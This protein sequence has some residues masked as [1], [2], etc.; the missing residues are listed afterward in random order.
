MHNAMLFKY[1]SI[2]TS[3]LATAR[4]FSAV[5]YPIL[6]V[7]YYFLIRSRFV[8]FMMYNLYCI[9]IFGLGRTFFRYKRFKRGEAPVWE[10]IP[11]FCFHHDNDNVENMTTEGHE[12]EGEAN[13]GEPGAA[14]A[15]E[16]DF[17]ETEP[18]QL[19]DKE[20]VAI[21]LECEKEVIDVDVTLSEREVES[22]LGGE[23]NEEDMDIQGAREGGCSV[24]GEKAPT[25]GEKCQEWWEKKKKEIAVHLSPSWLIP[26]TFIVV[27][28]YIQYVVLGNL[29]VIYQPMYSLTGMSVSSFLV[30]SSF[31]GPLGGMF[32]P[33]AG[34]IKQFLGNGTSFFTLSLVGV[35]VC[36]L[37]LILI[38]EVQFLTVLMNGVFRVAMNAVGYAYIAD[39]QPEEY[40]GTLTTDLMLVT[41][42]TALATYPTNYVSYQLL[43]G[44]MIPVTIFLLTLGILRFGAAIY[45]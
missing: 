37:L 34:T 44:D 35:S 28:V 39:E 7:I 33:L 21:A 16:G 30:V 23:E 9:V 27:A 13:G 24:S 32:G 29:P 8:V 6:F 36:I 22:A 18:Q 41:I 10:P 4:E 12:A 1:V 3:G 2:S 43:E 15:T 26:L 14:A 45:F 25:A 19:E 42:Y 40:Y 31:V 5:L 11:T 38:L 20:T 17:D